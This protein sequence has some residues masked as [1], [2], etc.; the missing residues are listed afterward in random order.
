MSLTNLLIAS[1]AAAA[2][3]LAAGAEAEPSDELSAALEC[4]AEAPSD[5]NLGLAIASVFIVLIVSFMGAAFPALLALKRH[6]WLVI[7]IK[8]G[9]FAGTGVLLATALVHMLLEANEN[10]SS[11]CLSETWLA[12]Y[13][14]F[15]Y[16]FACLTIVVLLTLDYI[17]F[18]T[19]GSTETPEIQAIPFTRAVSTV[20][21]PAASAPAAP[22]AE[23]DPEA[24]E[25]T[26]HAR[27]KDDECM[28]RVLLPHA[29]TLPRHKA[30]GS[31][32]VSEVSICV[33]S[34][35]IGL[36]LG[37]TS[38]G[39][40]TALFI[41][42]LF[43]QLLEGVALGSNASEAGFNTRAILVLASIYSVTTPVG[44][45]IGIGVRESLNTNSP[46]LL[47][48]TGILDA[49]AAGALIFL[50]LGDMNACKTQAEWLREQK[51][52]IQL[53]C[54]ASFFLGA[55]ALLVIALWA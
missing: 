37:V 35:V 46:T 6:P 22:D 8:F 48:T 21:L 28:G 41:A 26:A 44:I 24:G 29:P 15:G 43:H 5:Y 10:L 25:C 31:I 49:I 14:A 38:S 1:L 51:V 45:A 36:A 20:S 4:A 2:A 19:L 12:A 39:E 40:F 50:A 54:F 9:A 11:P 53:A 42:I 30:V 27:C 52:G 7:A 55:A 23:A 13:P 47:M 18:A 16:L 34:V 33:H 3:Q 32:I 17:L